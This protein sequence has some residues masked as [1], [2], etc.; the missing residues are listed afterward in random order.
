MALCNKVRQKVHHFKIIFTAAESWCTLGVLF[1]VDVSS[2]DFL[3]TRSSC[4]GLE[5]DLVGQC[6]EAALQVQQV[7]DAPADASVRIGQDIYKGSSVRR[8]AQ[9]LLIKIQQSDVTSELSQRLK[10]GK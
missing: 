4:K 8:T 6:S 5:Q 9:G 2:C 3:K 7:G 10:N 1:R